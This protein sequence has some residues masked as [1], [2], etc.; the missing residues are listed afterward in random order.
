MKKYQNVELKIVMIEA[1]IVTKSGQ[2]EEGMFGEDI[3]STGA[4]SQDFVI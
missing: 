1:D 2:D 4:K 3:F